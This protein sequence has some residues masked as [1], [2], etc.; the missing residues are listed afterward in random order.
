MLS[1]LF[2]QVW[3][4]YQ[5]QMPAACQPNRMYL[6]SLPAGFPE[7]VEVM[8]DWGVKMLAALRTTSELV[9]LG[10]GL[11]MDA[12]TRLMHNGPHLLGPTGKPPFV[13]DRMHL[14][15]SLSR[16]LNPADPDVDR[17]DAGIDLGRHLD[18]VNAFAGFHYDLNLMVRPWCPQP[19][20]P[21]CRAVTAYPCRACSAASLADHPWKVA[22]PRPICM[23]GRRK[24][25][26]C[27]NTHWLPTPASWQAA[28]MAHCWLRQGWHA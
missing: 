7:W 10:F 1:L 5:P 8:D 19:V 18:S 2:R 27:A 15:H 25:G 12:F 17:D 24:E 23:A 22:L 20:A 11:E 13:H 6:Q 26:A 14:A 3:K 4:A 21:D 28:R 16:M 9:A